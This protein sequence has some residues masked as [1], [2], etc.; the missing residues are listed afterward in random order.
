[1]IEYTICAIGAIIVFKFLR[2]FKRAVYHG[3]YYDEEVWVNYA[4]RKG[5]EPVYDR[6]DN[7]G[8]L[9]RICKGMCPLTW[10]LP[11]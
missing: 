3:V 5:Y 4:R 9:F 8:N 7:R 6:G 11:I 2:R 10:I 1:M